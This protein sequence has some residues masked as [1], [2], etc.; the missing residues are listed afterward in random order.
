MKCPLCHVEAKSLK[1]DQRRCENEKCVIL[2][3]RE[4]EN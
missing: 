2:E 1:W 3:F 4:V